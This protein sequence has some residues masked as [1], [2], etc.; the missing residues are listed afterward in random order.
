VIE[1][2]ENIE[3]VDNIAELADL[4]GLDDGSVPSGSIWSIS[5]ADGILAVERK[6]EGTVEIRGKFDWWPKK[7][8]FPAERVAVV[9]F[10]ADHRTV[11]GGAVKRLGPGR[12]STT[13][14]R[15]DVSAIEN[16]LWVGFVA[17]DRVERANLLRQRA[18]ALLEQVKTIACTAAEKD[19][20]PAAIIP[21]YDVA[22]WPIP[23]PPPRSAT[24]QLPLAAPEPPASTDEDDEDEDDEAEDDETA[25]DDDDEGRARI[26]AVVLRIVTPGDDGIAPPSLEEIRKDLQ[27]LGRRVGLDLEVVTLPWV[28]DAGAVISS[29]P[30]GEDDPRINGLLEVLARTAART[31]G[32][33]NALWIAVLPGAADVSVVSL[34]DAALGIGV[35]TREGLTRCVAELVEELEGQVASQRAPADTERSD[36]ASHRQKLVLARAQARRMHS[37]VSRLR[38]IGRVSG[39]ALEVFEPP[40]EEE[41]GAGRGAPKETGVVAVAL[42]G[43]GNEL[44]Y[45]PV[46]AHRTTLPATFAVLIP[47]SPEVDLVEFRRGSLVLFRIERAFGKPTAAMKLQLDVTN[48]QATARWTMPESSRPVSL[49]LEISARSDGNDWVPLT[50]LHTCAERGTVPLSRTAGASRVRLV[51]CDGWSATPSTVAQVPEGVTFGPLV[52]R[53]VNERTLWAEVPAGIAEVDWRT[54]VPRDPLQGKRNRRF[55]LATRQ[56]G[57]V[58]LS[59]IGDNFEDLIEL[60]ARD[61]YRRP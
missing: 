24:N 10:T 46:R 13:F 45:T 28:E 41:R 37:K 44:A 55:D 7:K 27:V 33:E 3:S 1:T 36:V 6:E 53:R 31:P 49:I 17:K 19:F 54:Q 2:I 42:D 43:A 12:V 57:K 20:D 18:R 30:T 48:G 22:A 60:G 4:A 9:G 47:I 40:R 5:H 26:S 39:N 35:A 38:V 56:E 15:E 8:P 14:R 34:A 58:E 25:D 21:D 11:F 50:T 23:E 51:A 32:R 59:A 16:V 52:V 61:V 29:V